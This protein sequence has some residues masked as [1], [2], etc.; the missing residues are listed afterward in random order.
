MSTRR[1]GH[2]CPTVKLKGRK[3]TLKVMQ[4]DWL[5]YKYWIN[6]LKKC[7]IKGIRMLH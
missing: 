6:I 7:V 2:K 1:T 3:L 5:L 4:V